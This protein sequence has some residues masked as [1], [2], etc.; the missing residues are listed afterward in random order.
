MTTEQAGKKIG[1]RS[2]SKPKIEGKGK[3]SDQQGTRFSPPGCAKSQ[4]SLRKVNATK[5]ST[6]KSENI[7]YSGLCIV[8]RSF[9]WMVYD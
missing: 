4:S 5:Q 8:I 3:D 7:N 9:I 6:D 1:T 2:M